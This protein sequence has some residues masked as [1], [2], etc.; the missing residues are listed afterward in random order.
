MGRPAAARAT[1][2]AREGWAQDWPEPYPESSE[3]PSGIPGSDTPCMKKLLFGWAFWQ[4]T[5]TKNTVFPWLMMF[6]HH[7]HEKTIVR[8][9]AVVFSINHHLGRDDD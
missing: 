7:G 5:V 1:F 2:I 6:Y 3:V 9:G 4:N 8:M